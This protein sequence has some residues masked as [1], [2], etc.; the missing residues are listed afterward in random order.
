MQGGWKGGR[1]GEREGG[2]ERQFGTLLPSAVVV[3]VGS[4]IVGVVTVVAPTHS[5]H[6]GVVLLPLADPDVP[7]GT[8]GATIQGHAHLGLHGSPG[9]AHE[10]PQPVRD[11]P[12]SH[13]GHPHATDD[14]LQGGARAGDNNVCV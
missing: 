11:V 2:R 10:V 3:Q 13:R 4:L 8:G 14:H 12:R 1:E 7:H 6:K 5:L 9:R